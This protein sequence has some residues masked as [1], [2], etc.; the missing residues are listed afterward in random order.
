MGFL[1]NL[2]Y[3]FFQKSFFSK[4]RPVT[5]LTRTLPDTSRRRHQKILKT[6]KVLGIWVMSTLQEQLLVEDEYH[7]LVDCPR[8]ENIRNGTKS[9]VRQ[10]VSADSYSRIFNDCTVVEAARLI[11]IRRIL[12]SRFP[13]QNRIKKKTGRKKTDPPNNAKSNKDEASIK[14]RTMYGLKKTF[15]IMCP[16]TW[17]CFILWYS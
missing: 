16:M 14:W 10:L 8:Y 5:F 1:V 13:K 7:I 11:F 12:E 4:K 9:E 15:N 3:T 6:V 17:V 2:K